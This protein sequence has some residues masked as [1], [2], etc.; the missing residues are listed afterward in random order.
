MI[1]AAVAQLAAQHAT[2]AHIERL[3]Q[4]QRNFRLAIR[5]GDTPERA[6]LNER[7]HA[8]MGEMADN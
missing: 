4:I 2:P 7:F 6:L 1:Y 5:N 8:A 3:K